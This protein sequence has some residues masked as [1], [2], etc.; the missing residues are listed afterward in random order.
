MINIEIYFKN[1][2][3]EAQERTGENKEMI[4]YILVQSRNA[5]GV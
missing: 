4:K 5:C 3:N 1:Y 2:E